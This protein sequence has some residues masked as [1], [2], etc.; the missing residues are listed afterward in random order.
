[1]A[2]KGIHENLELFVSVVLEVSLRIVPDDYRRHSVFS[3]A[4][5]TWLSSKADR[6]AAYQKTQEN[7]W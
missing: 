5:E 1:M 2:Q 6:E 7:M 3:I 4:S